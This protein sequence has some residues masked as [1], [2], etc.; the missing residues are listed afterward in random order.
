MNLFLYL[1]VVI[2]WGTTW[3]AIYAQQAASGGSVGAAVFWRF[4]VASLVMLIA[5][6][7]LK[8]LRRLTARDHLFCLLQGCCVFGFNFICFY[9]AA[10]WINSGLESVIF[11]MAVL[12]NALNSWF[13]FRLRPSARLLPA[14]VL[15]IGGIIALFWQ[16]LHSSEASV[17]LLWGMGLSA[18]GTLG[19]SLGNMIS[20]RHQRLQRDVLTTNSYAMLY[21]AL[22]IAL[23]TLLRGESLAPVWNLQWLGAL[24]YLA[25]F[26]SVIGFG[27]YFTLVGRIGASQAAYST[28]LFP[29]V[30]LALSTL[31]EGYQWH[32]G[33]L[34]GLTMILAGNLV[35]FARLPAFR[36]RVTA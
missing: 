11:S 26:G 3:I 20:L 2:I 16:D 14:I 35:M 23:F 29:L 9:H 6:K 15:G 12:Y 13:F 27:A 10:A 31:Y 4:I 24:G 8:R 36:R 18:L 30:A 7:A 32:A 34:L 5:L 33:A 21:G 22:A 19:F 28:L 1:S 17:T 25:I